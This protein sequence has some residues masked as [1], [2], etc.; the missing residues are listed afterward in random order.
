[1]LLIVYFNLIFIY[2]TVDAAYMKLTNLNLPDEN[3]L[4][5]IITEREPETMVILVILPFFLHR[6]R[7]YDDIDFSKLLCSSIKRKTLPY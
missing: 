3:F 4:L 7:I 6:F 2:L 1:M 5:A